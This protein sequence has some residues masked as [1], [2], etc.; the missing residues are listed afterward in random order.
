MSCSIRDCQNRVFCLGLCRSHYDKQRRR[1]QTLN[2][3]LS[4]DRN[5]YIDR[6]DYWLICL[7]DKKGAFKASTKIDSDDAQRCK[8]YK[9]CLHG[10]GYVLGS[11]G[12]A[13]KVL[14]HRFICGVTDPRVQIDHIHGDKLDNRKQVLR[15]CSN[16]QNHANAGLQKNNTSG[17]KGVYWNSRDE[18]WQ[19]RIQVNG[20]GISLGTFPNKE[21][22]AYAY[23]RHALMYFGRFAKL[24]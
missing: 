14:L 11:R 23:N 17:Y 13:E 20:Q 18:V 12:G 5:E 24:N 16:S 3:R 19:A 2:R 21:E 1:A 7:Y 4:T 9:W 8:M 15:R 10:K 22:A 6:G